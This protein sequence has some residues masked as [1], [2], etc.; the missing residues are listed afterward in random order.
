MNI[1]LSEILVVI[2]VA[3]LVV[4]PEQLPEMA[5]KLGKWSKQIRSALTSLRQDFD[6]AVKP[7]VDEVTLKAL[8]ETEVVNEPQKNA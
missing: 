3:L 7:L 5:Y 1:S 6:G 4:K 2:V 8:P